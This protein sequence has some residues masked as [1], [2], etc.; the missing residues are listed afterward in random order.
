VL[1]QREKSEE[2]KHQGGAGIFPNCESEKTDLFATGATMSGAGTRSMGGT[3]GAGDG[4]A[5]G[6]Y[7]RES[8][9]I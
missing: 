4:S 3:E 9:G 2:K 6:V 7:V 5:M 8:R 1:V